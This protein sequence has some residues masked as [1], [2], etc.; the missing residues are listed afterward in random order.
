[1]TEILNSNKRNIDKTNNEELLVEHFTEIFDRRGKIKKLREAILDLAVRGKL[2]PQNPDDEPVSILLEKI[3]EEKE[4]LIKE[5]KIKK[6]KELPRIDENEFKYDIPKSWEFVRLKDLGYNLGQKKPNRKFVYIDV[7]SVNKE[8]GIL[9]EDLNVLE[10]ENAPSRARKIV[11]KD[12]LI[13]S[14]VRPYLLN[15]SLIEKE[16]EYETIVST[17]FAVINT[18]K[19][20]YNKYLLYYLRSSI[21]IEYVESQMV[22]MAYPAINDQKLFMGVIAIPPYEEQKRI[23]KKVELL[24]NLCDKLE[25]ALEKK[26]HYKTLSAKSVFNSIG[27]VSNAEELEKTLEFIIKNFKELSLGDYAVEELKKCILQLAVQGK[28]VPQVEDDEPASILLDQIKI[29]KEELIKSKKIKKEKY[30]SEI[31]DYKYYVGEKWG[32]VKI[33]DISKIVTKQTGF[34]YSRNIKPNLINVQEKGYI[35]MIQTKNFKGYEFNFKTSYYIKKEIAEKFPKI[36]LNE[37]CILLSIVGASIGNVGI[38]DSPKISL[39]GGAICK[40]SLLNESMIEYLYYY[41][42]S[43]QG[44]KEIYKNYKSTAQGTIT[45]QDIRE[46]IVTVPPLAEQKRII[47]RVNDLMKLCDILEEKINESKKYNERLMN[48]IVRQLT[49]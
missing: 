27:L 26:I 43:P 6:E 21:F 30:N 17:A 16:F 36:L 33:G 11:N 37:K 15:I 25:K 7:A 12:S 18:F 5:K 48:S 47:K 42:K 40:V 24:M 39:L 14:T 32:V 13:Y 10:P 28:L 29:K 3:K 9:N 2:V 20:I 38:Y 46:I 31:E 49:N 44:Q 45:V 23:V 34:D 1:M 41:L 8:L 4:N 35:P 22:G 19:G